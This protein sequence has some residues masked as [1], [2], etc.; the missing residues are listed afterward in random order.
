MNET[1]DTFAKVP[2]DEKPTKPLPVHTAMR[3]HFAKHAG[4]YVVTFLLGFQALCTGFYDNF[5]I[6]EPAGMEKLGWWQVLAAFGK[7]LS[8]ALGIAV[9]YILKPVETKT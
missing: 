6:I 1:P 3:V 5:W 9:G 7:S 8:F 2:E 4:M